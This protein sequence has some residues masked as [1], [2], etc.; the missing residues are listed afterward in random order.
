MNFFR[1]LVIPALAVAAVATGCGHRSAA[2]ATDPSA[3]M[4]LDSIALADSVSR[5]GS[6]ASVNIRLVYPVGGDAAADSIRQWIA[7]VMS[8]ASAGEYGPTAFTA[9][10]AE[11]VPSVAREVA[12]S[13]LAMSA[14]DFASMRSEMPDR[15][16]SYTFDYSADTVAVTPGYATFSFSGYTYQGGAH[17][18]AYV[19]PALFA[20]PSGRQITWDSLIA[21]GKQAQLLDMI[22]RA[23]M[24]QY[25]E[26]STTEAL[27]DMLLVS[28]SEI[29][30]PAAGPA[31]TPSGLEVIYQ[32]Y[33]IAPYA[34]GMPSC[35]IPMDDLRPLLDPS[36][37]L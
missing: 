34:A 12:D 18:S 6:Q 16:M 28:P 23:L 37:H 1:H 19:I 26:V 7:D 13:L 27:A 8:A 5:D 4:P 22:R 9:S 30:L 21:P 10:G 29:Q 17:G 32:Q 31:L 20:I 36:R 35:T 24:E 14:R 3:Y 15:D 25:F 33:E 11:S 2:P